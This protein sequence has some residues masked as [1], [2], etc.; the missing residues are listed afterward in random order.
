MSQTSQAPSRNTRFTMVHKREF[1][2]LR[3]NHLFAYMKDIIIL[4]DYQDFDIVQMVNNNEKTPKNLQD[5][6][7]RILKTYEED[8]RDDT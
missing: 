7:K 4:S 6:W 1:A 2:Q 3:R 8:Q 5:L